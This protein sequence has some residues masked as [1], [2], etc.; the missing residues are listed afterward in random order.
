MPDSRARATCAPTTRRPIADARLTELLGALLG[1]WDFAS[2]V[3]R[4]LDV[5]ERDPLASGGWF[6]GD[7]VRG[8]MEVPGA[9]WARHP[10]LYA[11]YQMVLRA[12]A[13]ARRTLP[14]EQRM[15]FWSPLADLPRDAAVEH[16]IDHQVHPRGST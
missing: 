3:P 12:S 7:I 15:Q 6:T 14:I 13:E 9:F 1:G 2:A 4:A 11:R 5:A 16:P 8:L 10:T